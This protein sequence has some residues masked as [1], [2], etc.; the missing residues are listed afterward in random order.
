MG[1]SA[2]PPTLGDTLGSSLEVRNPN[3]GATCAGPTA[4]SRT[5]FQPGPARLRW[6]PAE[7]VAKRTYQWSSDWGPWDEFTQY[8]R[9]HPMRVEFRRSVPVALLLGVLTVLAAFSLTF[10]GLWVPRQDVGTGL[11]IASAGISVFL[12][13]R[14]VVVDGT[15]QI[16][17]RWWGWLYR[18]VLSTECAVSTIQTIEIRRTLGPKVPEYGVG[19]DARYPLYLV[20]D[21]GRPIL[22]KHC[23]WV[24]EARFLAEA[25]SPLVSAPVSDQS[26]EPL[27]LEEEGL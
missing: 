15:R 26:G 25:L 7:S 21:E 20:R 9:P 1:E 2:E 13:G 10:L 3:P 19:R 6:Y 11:L 16:V 27:D 23:P 24:S 5:N 8:R 4:R 14:G 18:P 12:L 22:V 17:R